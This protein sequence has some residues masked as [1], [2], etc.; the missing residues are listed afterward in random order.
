MD[1]GTFF[2]ILAADQNIFK[3]S[4]I[5][6]MGCT[7]RFNL[8][9]FSSK[10]EERLRNH[11]SLICSSPLS[12][13][14]ISNW[15]IDSKAVSWTDVGYSFVISTSIKQVK[16]LELILSV[17]FA[18]GSCCC[19]PTSCVQ[20]ISPYK[21][22]RWLLGF[23]NKTNPPERESR[24]IRSGQIN[25]LVHS[26]KKEERE[27]C[28]I[29]RPGR[30]RRTTVMMIGGSSPWWRKTLSQHPAKWRT[31]SRRQT[32]LQSREDF[33]RA[34]TEGSARAANKARLD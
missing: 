12:Q 14:T 24:N 30:P 4:Y 31:L 34:N 26:E 33:T 27:L 10:L 8:R 3:Y 22:N 2:I 29:K 21:R 28:N 15:T 16:G 19:E 32:C 17:P 20:R 18:F 23:K 13:G 5:M 6:I 9:A 25:S 7:L 1:T 11:S